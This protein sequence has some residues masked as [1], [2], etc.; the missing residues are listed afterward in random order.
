MEVAAEV[1]VKAPISDAVA[2][3]GADVVILSEDHPALTGRGSTVLRSQQASLKL[4]AVGADGRE[5]F[6]Y[7]LRPVRIALGELSPARLAAAIRS[8]LTPGNGTET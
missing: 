6:L 8:E 2:E 5:G 1:P 4:L 7:A 3:S